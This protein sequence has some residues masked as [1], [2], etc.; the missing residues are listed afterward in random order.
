MSTK[1]TR[2]QLKSAA[3]ELNSVLGLEPEIDVKAPDFEIV[4]N[5]LEAMSLIEE[6]DVISDKTRTVLNQISEE[7]LK[8][9]KMEEVKKKKSKSKSKEEE[10]EPEEESEPETVEHVTPEYVKKPEPRKYPKVRE[11]KT[12]EMTKFILRSM[13]DGLERKRISEL[14]V[15]KFPGY[16]KST[17]STVFSMAKLFKEIEN[18]GY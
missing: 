11:N 13:A 17:I 7:E 10:P 8:E 15:K 5:L 3:K 14:V 18:E 4:D 16:K 1:I 12:K 9:T 2:A 6:G